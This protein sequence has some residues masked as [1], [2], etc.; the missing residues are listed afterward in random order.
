MIT[1][2]SLTGIGNNTSERH[3]RV[4]EKSDLCP[5]L[6]KMEFL[7]TLLVLVLAVFV[8]SFILLVLGTIQ[9][10]ISNTEIPPGMDQPIKLRIIHGF[11]V[12]SAVL[13]SLTCLDLSLSLFFF[14]LSLFLRV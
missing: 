2:M 9:F 1:C 13:V 3:R 12:G 4:Q 14:S 11:L 6:S 5:L 10:E 8:A 7:F